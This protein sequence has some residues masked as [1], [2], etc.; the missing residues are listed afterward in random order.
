[1]EIDFVFQVND[2]NLNSVPQRNASGGEQIIIKIEFYSLVNA[3]VEIFILHRCA[4][5][6]LA[7]NTSRG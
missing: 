5:T 4:E 6:F 1:M 7:E 3:V 2:D